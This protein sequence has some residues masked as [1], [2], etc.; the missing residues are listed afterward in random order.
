MDI[1]LRT[2]KIM[3]MDRNIKIFNNS[4]VSGVLNMTKE[5]SVSMAKIA[6]EYG[7]D[8]S[9][10]E[11]VLA[12]ELPGLKDKN[13]QVLEG[14]TYLGVSE[15]A[16]SGIV[17]MFMCRCKESSV[18]SVGRFMNRELLRIFSENGISV[19]FPHVTISNWENN[20]QPDG[21]Q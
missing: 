6:I 3:G 2:T 15:L 14:P 19:P 4:E 18:G 5:S 12:R 17:L 10:V 13:E 16:D 11:D 1:G 20:D 21:K 8:L 7:Q 9:Y